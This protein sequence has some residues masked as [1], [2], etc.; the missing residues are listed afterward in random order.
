MS[1]KCRYLLLISLF[2]FGS[3]QCEEVKDESEDECDEESCVPFDLS[4]P[5]PSRIRCTAHVKVDV[6]P[7]LIRADNFVLKMHHSPNYFQIR[8]SR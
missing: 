7:P 5:H 4:V 1:R 3:D 6:L 2:H 8:G